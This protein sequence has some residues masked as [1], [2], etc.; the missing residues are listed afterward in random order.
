ML[1]RT[2]QPIVT[3]DGTVLTS[4]HVPAQGR[5]VGTALMTN[6]QAQHIGNLTRTIEG[7]SAR[8]FDVVAV[9]LRGHG[10]SAGRRA[11]L[12][13]MDPG[14]GWERLTEDFL[15]AAAH[16][17]NGVP[18]DQR[19]VIAANIGA[20][21]CLEAL[22]ARPDLARR[23]VLAAPPPNQPALLR[24]AR[25]LMRVRGA[26]SASTQPDELTM[27]QLYTFLGGQ[28]A[29]RTRLIDVVSADPEVTAELEADP[30]SWPTPTIGYFT[31]LFRGIESAWRWPPGVRLAPGT[32]MLIL[33]GGD[34]PM[35]ARGAYVDRMCKALGKI[36]PDT[37]DTLCIPGG[38]AGLL[39]DE[40]TL[41]ISRHIAD[42][43]A[44]GAA[45]VETRGAGDLQAVTSLVLEGLG[46]CPEPL[47]PDALVE[48][49][50]TAIGNEARWVELLYRL[51]HSM[52][53][54]EDGTDDVLAGLMPHYARALQID[55]Q[56]MS[57]AAVGTVL[58]GVLDRLGIGLAIVTRDLDI[59]FANAAFA[60][61]LGALSGAVLAQSDNAAMGAALRRLAAPAFA[62][63]V[64]AGGDRVAL[65][66][67]G[68]VLGVHFRPPQ[69]R[70][71]ALMRGGASGVIA[72]RAAGEDTTAL[73]ELLQF[74]HGLTEKEAEV[75]AHLCRGRSPD[76]IA[77]VMG[78]S[79]HTTRTHLKRAFEKTG[80][81]G[82]TELVALVM[83]GPLGLFGG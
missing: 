27:H 1:R 66:E 37:L 83:N 80:T 17:F 20:P 46:A 18:W 53:E 59:V 65:G 3:P 45:P 42:W 4:C 43:C 48:L 77:T 28:I 29:G 49:C 5:R 7:L 39:I 70:Q 22:K 71:A 24:F 56:I 54:D 75:V 51:A 36:G 72:M 26:M 60:A 55:R 11:P 32:Q 31:E 47:S 44:G 10:G 14:I 81:A 63:E 34:D 78:V 25:A 64:R 30:L 82:Q 21:L 68:E 62:A 35:T 13:H 41:E 61:R 73:A 57:A 74:V 79:L 6:T 9:D 16:A 15:A 23:I 2:T 19:L 67:G 40:R 33:Y 58:Q 69:L 8:G 52:A 12:A 38:R 76:A 50:Y